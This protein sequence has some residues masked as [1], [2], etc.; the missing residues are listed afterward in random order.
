MIISQQVKNRFGLSLL[1]FYQGWIYTEMGRFAEAITRYERSVQLN[2]DLGFRDMA[3]VFDIGL[4][5]LFQKL[6]DAGAAQL[7]FRNSLAIARKEGY[8]IEQARIQFSQ[9]EIA[10]SYI[11]Y[12]TAEECYRETMAIGQENNSETAALGLFG[13][14]KVM[15]KLGDR[16]AAWD[17]FRQALQ[18]WMR[19]GATDYLSY[20]LEAMAVLAASTAPGLALTTSAANY[21]AHL[22]GAGQ[23]LSYLSRLTFYYQTHFEPYDMAV[24]LAPARAVLGEDAYAHAFAEGQAMK[25]EQ[26]VEYAL[27]Y[28]GL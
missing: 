25:L 15:L 11:D 14:G 9:G 6:G 1:L 28:E 19:F 26:A 16:S 20:V 18:T 8:S 10:W 24:C 13:L 23:A 4:A 22:Q 2:L 27:N 17:Y 3:V 7:H 12:P 5:S 21:A